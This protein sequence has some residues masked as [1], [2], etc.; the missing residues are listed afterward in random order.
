MSRANNIVWDSGVVQSS[1]SDGV[2][3]GGTTPLS[4]A[5]EYGVSVELTLV[6]SDGAAGTAATA[7][8]NASE[9]CNF[10]TFPTS[11]GAG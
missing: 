7:A 2:L 11:G 8:N 6:A 5:T 9:W 4:G 1:T 10:F 3:Y